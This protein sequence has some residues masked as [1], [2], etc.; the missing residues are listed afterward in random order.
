MKYHPKSNSRC[1]R[2]KDLICSNLLRQYRNGIPLETQQYE[3][4]GHPLSD[5]L[6]IYKEE[7]LMA[8]QSIP[9]EG[10]DGQRAKVVAHIG[11]SSSLGVSILHGYS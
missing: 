11:Q 2:I 8:R 10:P 1:R 5:R 9:I 3:N 4:N 7:G 6:I